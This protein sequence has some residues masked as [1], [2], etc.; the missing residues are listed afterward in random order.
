VIDV[1]VAVLDILVVGVEAAAAA[2]LLVVVIGVILLNDLN[3]LTVK[4]H[5]LNR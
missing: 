1:L 2:G 4:D 3:E 5:V